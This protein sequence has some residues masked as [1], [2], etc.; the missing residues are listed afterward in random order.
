[1]AN[2]A[3]IFTRETSTEATPQNRPIP[4]R[5]KEMRLN[6]AGGYVFK[7]PT[8]QFILRFLI[9]GSETGTY[10]A[11]GREIT[12][13]VAKRVHQL[14]IEDAG[15]LAT[16]VDNANKTTTLEDGTVLA[17]PA[18]RKS[19]S[20]FAL[21]VAKVFAQTDEARQV[22]HDV[23]RARNVISTFGQMMEFLAYTYQMTGSGQPRLD[24]RFPHGNGFK[25]ALSDWAIGVGRDERWLAMQFAKYRNRNFKIG[26]PDRDTRREYD[27][28][29]SRDDRAV[30]SLSARDFLRMAHIA[31]ETEVQNVIF[32]W[33]VN[34]GRS[35]ND[36]KNVSR[37]QVLA[38][39][40]EVNG[41]LQSPALDYIA[42]F[43]ELQT[44]TDGQEAARLVREYGLTWE[45]IPSHLYGKNAPEADR[46]AV[47]RTLLGLDGAKYRMP[48]TALMRNLPRMSA[49]GL[50]K[51]SDVRK[52]IRDV[53]AGKDAEE[54]LVKARVHPLA[55]LSAHRIYTRG[56]TVGK[57]RGRYG[58]QEIKRLEW[59]PDNGIANALEK[60]YHMSFGLVEPVGSRVAYFLDT[61]GSMTSGDVAG[62]EGLT[63]MEAEAVM[64]A[65][66]VRTED[67]WLAFGFSSA[68]DGS[69]GWGRS[70][71]KPRG[72]FG[73]THLP[74][75]ATP[76]IEEALNVIQ[77][78]SY[79]GG[80]DC[81]IPFMWATANKEYIDLFVIQTDNQT[82]DNSHYHPSQ[83][84][85]E[86]RR[87]VNPNARVAVIGY[88]VNES[89]I[90]DPNDA[91]TMEFV[92]FDASSPAMLAR[93]GRGE[94]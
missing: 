25:R 34:M 30:L 10:Y 83:A 85:E 76:S 72:D 59:T 56:Y 78:Y 23:I 44:L 49:Y 22:V 51:D 70:S 71:G 55:L 32:G 94:F 68:P 20:L 58:L 45:M 69:R 38:T 36:D 67:D 16:L 86:Y 88:T 31:P 46:K 79:V 3:N 9:Q 61:S 17:A 62:I 5:E 7:T 42:A 21:A 11:T 8:D 26:D 1:M 4:G 54:V 13:N 41:E 27:G 28:S 2:Y 33:A 74:F 48:F 29:I 57:R 50:T 39:L 91:Q 75:S 60:A 40:R 64:T 53:F 89:S 18:G 15:H 19:P 93:F 35:S 77:R 82:W 73:L 12:L 52:F 37:E 47:W 24:G 14:A 43:E 87:V 63:P 81:A 66:L 90:A 80:T 65:T 6:E 92:G 84:L